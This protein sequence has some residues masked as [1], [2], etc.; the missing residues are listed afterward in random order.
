ME[1][2]TGKLEVEIKEQ[3]SRLEL[4]K[5]LKNLQEKQ[6][7]EK[8]KI[9]INENTLKE[10]NKKIEN[11][12][13]KQGGKETNNLKEDGEGKGEKLVNKLKLLIALATIFAILTLLS[14][15]VIKNDIVT[16]LSIVL[17]VVTLIYT[18]YTQNKKKIGIINKE[19]LQNVENNS[20]KNEIEI[21]TN[22]CKKLQEE[23]NKQGT[24]L[25]E[26]YKLETEKLRNKYIGIIPIKIIDEILSKETLIYDINVLQNKIS[27]D[28]IKLHSIGLDKSSI[29]PKLENLASLEEEFS[30]LEE[31]YNDL[32]TKNEQINLVKQEI[33]KAYDTMKKDITPKFTNNLSKI[34]EKISKGKYKNVQLSEDG[35]MIVEVQNG[36]YISAKN[37]SIGTIDQMYLSLRLGAGVEIS[38]EKLPIILDETFAYWDNTRLENILS[39]LNE[40]FKDRQI[41]LFTCTNREKDMLDKLGISYNKLEL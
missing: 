4:L 15:F 33:E 21:L 37:L 34:I 24:K 7:L 35:G 17:L 28:K 29:L 1:E 40:E 31:Q 20:I 19:N 38:E 11:L 13:T 25:K 32:Y 10:Y 36:N 41:I 27:Q 39:Y 30:A 6:Q 22:S 12:H 8:E 16:A 5:E 9:K 26:E 2:E 3:E 23:I 14:I 18:G